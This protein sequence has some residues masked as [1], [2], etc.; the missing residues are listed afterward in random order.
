MS[1]Q[2]IS[3]KASMK[4]EAFFWLSPKELIS[5]EISIKNIGIILLS[6]VIRCEFGFG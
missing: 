2:Y 5:Q 1:K 3:G 6:T 4:I